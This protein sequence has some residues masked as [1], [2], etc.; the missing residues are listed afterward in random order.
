[1]RDA[2]AGE[3]VLDG[4]LPVGW[5]EGAVPIDQGDHER[6][7]QPAGKAA[8]RAADRAGRTLESARDDAMA[9]PDAKGQLEQGLVLF[10]EERDAL[11][12]PVRRFRRRA[13]QRGSAFQHN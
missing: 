7:V 12:E 13:G 3:E 1:V 6:V 2:P 9:R 8:D 4:D 5:I 10:G 11:P